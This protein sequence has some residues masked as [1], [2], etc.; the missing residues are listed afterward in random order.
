MA[1]PPLAGH[2]H[3]DPCRAAEIVRRAFDEARVMKYG[4]QRLHCRL[5][6]RVESGTTTGIRQVH[7][8]LIVEIVDVRPTSGDCAQ[9]VTRPQLLDSFPRRMYAR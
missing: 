6:G 2:R 7:Q 5:I 8:K 1:C 3:C 9:P 4:E